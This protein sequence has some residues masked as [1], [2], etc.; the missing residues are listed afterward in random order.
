MLYSR[1]KQGLL[2]SFGAIFLKS[3][4]CD[5]MVAGYPRAIQK[6]TQKRTVRNGFRGKQLL[7]QILY[8]MLGID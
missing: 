4:P 3:L 5:V 2:D 7:I 6:S 1:L 8:I